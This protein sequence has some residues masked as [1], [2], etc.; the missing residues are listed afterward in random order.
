M[1]YIPRDKTPPCIDLIPILLSSLSYVD[2]FAKTFNE[3][4]EI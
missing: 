2:S 1:I 3:N 4:G